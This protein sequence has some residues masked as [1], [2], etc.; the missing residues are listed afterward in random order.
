MQNV[1]ICNYFTYSSRCRSADIYE[2]NS[3][4]ST[5]LN[6]PMLQSYVQSVQFISMF[7]SNTLAATGRVDENTLLRNCREIYIR[8][9]RKTRTSAIHSHVRYTPRLA[10]NLSLKRITSLLKV[11]IQTRHVICSL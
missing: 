7:N 4:S 5:I 2:L 10:T 6:G 11:K 8:S 9:F 1:K 3:A